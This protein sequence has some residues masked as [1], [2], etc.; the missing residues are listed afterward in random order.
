MHAVESHKAASD[1]TD[2]FGLG[3][4]ECHLE[5]TTGFTKQISKKKI[6]TSFYLLE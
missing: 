6:M 3:L 4:E 1:L 2:I 5:H